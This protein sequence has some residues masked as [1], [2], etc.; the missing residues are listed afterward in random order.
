MIGPDDLAAL[1]SEAERELAEPGRWGTTF[2][3][4]Q[5]GR[6][7]LTEEAMDLDELVFHPWT[8]QGRAT[9]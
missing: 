9:C 4:I 8:V 3:L 1:R 6:T 7:T 5:L 2:T